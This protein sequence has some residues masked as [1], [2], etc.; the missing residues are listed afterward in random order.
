MNDNAEL[1]AAVLTGAAVEE[2]T[3]PLQRGAELFIDNGLFARR[4]KRL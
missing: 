3:L 1:V 2:Q 4:V